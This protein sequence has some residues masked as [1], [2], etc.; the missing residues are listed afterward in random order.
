MTPK[1]VR[2]LFMYVIG[3]WAIASVFS[4]GFIQ[5]AQANGVLGFNM[6]LI[7]A[8]MGCYGGFLLFKREHENR[9]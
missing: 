8:I 4:L 9:K 7:G 5:L 2:K 1:D 6:G 3:C